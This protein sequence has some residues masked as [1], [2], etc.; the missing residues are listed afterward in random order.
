MA[1]TDLPRI[2]CADR[3]ATLW[4]DWPGRPVNGWNLNNLRAFDR[5]LTLITSRPDHDVLVIRSARPAG[6]CA[7]FSADALTHL[8]SDTDWTAFA[9]AGQNVFQ[10][11]S[12][13][14]LITLAFVEGTCLG[15]GFELALA[16]DYR[17]AVEGPNSHIGFGEQPTCWGGR[18]RW[19]QLS[20][21]PAPETAN[22]RSLSI[23]DSVCCER[24]AKIDLQTRLDTLLIH[25]VKRRAPWRS[26][27]VNAADGFADERKQFARNRQTVSPVPW[28]RFDTANPIPRFPQTV[29][30]VGE[31][32]R[33]NELAWEIA[34]RGQRVVRLTDEIPLARPNRMT[35]L[36]LLQAESRMT[37]TTNAA[38]LSACGLVVVDD[39]G[40]APAFLE[41]NLPARTILAV[42]P[43]ES[44]RFVELAKRPE[45]VVGLE[46][47]GDQLAVVYPQFETSPDTLAAFGIWLEF[48][49][50]QPILTHEVGTDWQ[51]GVPGDL[52]RRAPAPKPS[53]RTNAG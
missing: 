22:P 21:R 34:L 40:V 10:K 50:Y 25:P 27:F 48:L 41:H 2:T 46:F 8:R 13:A 5:A 51:N 17:L 23:F 47:A 16:C 32:L 33:S 39:S 38:D 52:T 29:G 20:G 35:P 19:R 24:R 1:D 53:L 37:Q 42:A 49:G 9:S 31:G 26:W 36:E 28:P 30:L 12:D 7:G 18:T 44:A 3:V 11:L 43:A 15:P 4:L 14:P 6:F 45:R